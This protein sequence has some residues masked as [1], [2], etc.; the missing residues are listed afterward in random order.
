MTDDDGWKTDAC[1]YYKLTYEPSA[2]VGQKKCL[3]SGNPTDPIFWE[4]TLIFLE[5]PRIF[6]LFLGNFN[7]NDFYAFFYKKT[8]AG[9]YNILCSNSLPL[10]VNSHHVLFVKQLLFLCFIIYSPEIFK[11]P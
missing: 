11:G 1:L 9:V 7:F 8:R 10:T 4:P 6:L 3:V 5:H 2:Q